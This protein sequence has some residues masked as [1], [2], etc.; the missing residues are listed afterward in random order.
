[1]ALTGTVSGDGKLVQYD[2]SVEPV[3]INY[4]GGSA[5][6]RKKTE[7]SRYEWYA[8]DE[9]GAIAYV[10][11]EWAENESRGMTEDSRIVGSWTVFRIV[12]EVTWDRWDPNATP[13]AWVS[14]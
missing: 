8:I 6:Y 14:A 1:M 4:S 10:E 5:K 3:Y 2:K 9:A 11:A 7:V 12:E 13:P